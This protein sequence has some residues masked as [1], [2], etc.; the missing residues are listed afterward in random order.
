MVS[1]EAVVLAIFG[2]TGLWSLLTYLV[3][4][5]DKKV[6]TEGKMLRGLAHDRILALGE[7][8][9]KRGSVDTDEYENLH[10]YLYIPYKELGGNGTAEKI[11]EDVRKLPIKEVQR[12][13][14]KSR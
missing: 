3:Q 10:D 9:I 6:S 7:E 8:Y 13:G 12:N 11:M 2:S 1:I 5:R 4:R 14:S